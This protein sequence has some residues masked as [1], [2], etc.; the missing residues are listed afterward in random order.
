[1]RQGS[2]YLPTDVRPGEERNAS[3]SL[4]VGAARRVRDGL[5]GAVL[6]DDHDYHVVIRAPT[7]RRKTMIVELP[8]TR[9]CVA[10]HLT[11]RE[12]ELASKAPG[13]LPMSRWQV[14]PTCKPRCQRRVGLAVTRIARGE[15]QPCLP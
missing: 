6:E 12:L 5:A 10:T 13:C 8:C 14:Q 4:E 15:A 11:K 7:A 3:E 9:S 1:M 2:R